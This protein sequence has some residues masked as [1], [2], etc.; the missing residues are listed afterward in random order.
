MVG[1]DCRSCGPAG[2]VINRT[3]SF[4]PDCGDKPIV[5]VPALLIGAT[6]IARNDHPKRL[7]DRFDLIRWEFIPAARHSYLIGEEEARR[8]HDF[9]SAPHTYHFFGVLGYNCVDFAQKAYEEAGLEGHFVKDLDISRQVGLDFW[10]LIPVA[11]MAVYEHTHPYHPETVLTIGLLALA[12]FR[13]CRKGYAL[14]NLRS[15]P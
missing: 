10:G 1:L 3:Y 2:G 14:L 8:V 7:D 13:L 5:I 6:G 11:H 4:H 9:V 12:V 15:L